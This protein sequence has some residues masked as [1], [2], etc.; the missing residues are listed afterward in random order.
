MLAQSEEDATEVV[1]RHGAI[2]IRPRPKVSVSVGAQEIETLLAAT[3]GLVLIKGKWV[4]VDRDKLGEVLDQ[5]RDVQKQAQAGGVSFGEAMRMLAG[6]QLD[7]GDADGAEDARPEWSE[8]IAGK[9]LS[10][11]LDALRSPELRAEIEAGAG[12]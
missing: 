1:E 2:G 4:E 11:R 12:L 7:G 10:S 8:V 3:E 9:W 6:A 5:W